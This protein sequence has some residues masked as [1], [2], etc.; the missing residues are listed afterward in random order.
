M[1]NKTTPEVCPSCKR[2]VILGTNPPSWTCTN[3]RCRFSVEVKYFIS[4][5]GLANPKY[6]IFDSVE[7][8]SICGRFGIIGKDENACDDFTGEE[9]FDSHSDCKHCFEKAGIKVK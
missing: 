2:P 3:E 6:H 5:P 4:V 1:K 9:T 7:N 8:K